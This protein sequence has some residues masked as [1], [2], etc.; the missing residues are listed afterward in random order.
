M[1][2]R[3]TRRAIKSLICGEKADLPSI[4]QHLG[5]CP[6]CNQKYGPGLAMIRSFQG[7]SAPRL[8]EKAWREFSARLRARIA[9][10]QPPSIGWW[11]SFLLWAGQWR[12][13]R[14]RRALAAVPVVA[15]LVVGVVTFLPYL[16]PGPGEPDT[17]VQKEP[18]EPL[19]LP[20]SELP[21]AAEDAISILGDVGFVTG[22][23]SG[24]IQPGD[25]IG[26]RELDAERI[27]EA[28]D[29][30]LPLS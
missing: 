8:D 15:L 16:S 12:L 7:V 4:R 28:L 25:F 19:P 17:V 18:L 10:E 26:G 11:R 27:I 6:N 24:N 3:R 29:Y 30:L 9:A 5:V 2:C 21:P 22:V 23:I 13:L 14:F 20:L 1:N